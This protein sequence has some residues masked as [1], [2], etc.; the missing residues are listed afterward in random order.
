[1]K[2][3]TLALAM[4]ASVAAIALAERRRPLR[5]ASSPAAPR[6]ARNLAMGAMCAVVVALAEQPMTQAIARTNIARRRGLAGLA[7]RPLAPV[8]A[9]LAMDYGFYRWHVATHRVPLLWRLHRVHHVDPDLDMST[10]IR[11]HFVDMV[12]SLPWQ[13]VQV[14]LSGIG[15]RTLL[16]WRRFF[17]LSILFHHANWRLPGQ[18]D[19]RLS[20]LLTTPRM[21]GIH[22]SQRLAERE[23]NWSSGISLWDRLHGTFV[24]GVDQALI[25]IGIDDSAATADVALLPAIAAPFA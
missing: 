7:P 17:F 10:A 4:A 18:W 8:V 9:F 16:A 19:D 14:R 22:H 15:P 20:L 12:V 5:P 24:A 25:P 13:A 1:M 2:R 3:S 21:H 23:S 11:F 6:I